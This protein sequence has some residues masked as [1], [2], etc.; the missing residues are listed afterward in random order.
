MLSYYEK[1]M[2]TKNDKY[3]YP[4]AITCSRRLYMCNYPSYEVM[5]EKIDYAINYV[6]GFQ[7]P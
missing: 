1:I 4:V 2:I 6:T 5:V 3:L 7:N